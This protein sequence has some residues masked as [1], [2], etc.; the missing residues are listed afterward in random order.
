MPLAAGFFA[1]VS[2]EVVSALG[3][4]LIHALWQ[5]TA[6][7]A[8]AALAMT[9]WRR[10]A[11]RYGVAMV[12]LA[13]SVLA[14][15]L[16]FFWLLG[17]SPSAAPASTL[18]TVLAPVVAA[19]ESSHATPAPIPASA[20]VELLPWLVFLWLMGVAAFGLRAAG[21]LW[22]VGRMGRRPSLPV[23]AE[24][25]TL[26][27]AL[28]SHLGIARAVRYRV[29]T[30]LEAP[31]VLGW[32]RPVVFLPVTA[33]T[34]LTPAQLRL[35]IAH[36]LAHIR[37]WDGLANL[38][39]VTSET[40]LFYHPAVWWL[41]RRIRI[42]RE[43]SCDDLALSLD[44]DP[45][46][47]ARALT[48]MAA[49][50]RAP[51]LAMGA[52]SGP[53][54]TRV[55]RILGMAAERPSG[56]SAGLLCLGLALIVGHALAQPVAEPSL[57]GAND[58]TTAIAVTAPSPP[59]PEQPPTPRTVASRA[60]TATPARAKLPA[61]VATRRPGSPPGGD[62]EEALDGSILNQFSP[63]ER[64]TLEIHGITNEELRALRR[65][66]LSPNFGELVAFKVHGVTPSYVRQMSALL[67]SL[68]E[69]QLIAMR[70]HGID[71][72]FARELTAEGLELRAEQLIALKVHDVTPRRIAGLRTLGLALEPAEV[73]ALQV[74]EI[75][76]ETIAQWQALGFDLDAA[77]V[78]ALQVHGVRLDEVAAF[79]ELGFEPRVEDFIALRRH[80]I[81]T[82]QARRAREHGE[83][84]RAARMI[85][86]QRAGKLGRGAQPS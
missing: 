53:L 86:L 16:T 75:D 78:I 48:E 83:A 76:P 68:D 42:E 18:T 81:T 27:R 71:P 6:L 11:I 64:A 63:R 15:V 73:I 45:L 26:G 72:S 40:L 70:S 69:A 8:L 32:L 29:C 10:A 84:P 80:G 43:H 3:W 47:Y 24:I 36:E 13:G 41:N 51:R 67:T 57:S 60:E 2:S 12:A 74:H 66:G 50:R 30:W 65:E 44:C 62:T 4:S 38:L 7:A 20:P 82:A 58:I 37:R 19:L 52:N 21:G 33:L 49:W 59:L 25:L 17:T 9:L 46:D 77:K 54:T 35:V 22:L 34:G 31:A 61:K 5:G 14:P 1:G 39:Q 56:R 85:A 79:L 23:P 28:E 55:R